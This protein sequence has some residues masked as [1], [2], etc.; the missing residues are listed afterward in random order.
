MPNYTRTWLVTSG[1]SYLTGESTSKVRGWFIEV[2]LRDDVIKWKHFP[3]YWP[4][5]RGIRRSPVNSPHKGQWRGALMFSL[6]CAWINALVNNR[7]AGDLKRHRAHFDVI[8]MCTLYL[9]MTMN[10]SARVCVVKRCAITPSGVMIVGVRKV[11]GLTPILST[12]KVSGKKVT[13]KRLTF[14]LQFIPLPWPRLRRHWKR[15]HGGQM[16]SVLS[17]VVRQVVVMASCTFT[18]DGKI[19]ITT[20]LF[21]N[22]KWYIYEIT[23]T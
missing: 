5:V 4:F 1:M 21:S 2:S 23:L 19:G 11:H 8:L 18:S 13:G 12:V 17:L 9:Q 14:N 10:A 3:R 6:I 15:C 22:V 7:E 20:T 16:P